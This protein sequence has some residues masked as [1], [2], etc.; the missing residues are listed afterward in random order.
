VPLKSSTKNSNKASGRNQ[1]QFLKSFC[2][3]KDTLNGRY[4]KFA[5][6]SSN[7]LFS[8]IQKNKIIQN[9]QLFLLYYLFIL[10]SEDFL[11]KKMALT[12][13]TLALLSTILAVPAS[14]LASV[15]AANTHF[16]DI[17]SVPWARDA[18]Q[19]LTASGVVHGVNSTQFDPNHSITREQFAKLVDLN[20]GLD[21]VSNMIPFKDVPTN[22]WSFDSIQRAT[23]YMDYYKSLSGSSFLFKPTVEMKRQD[24]AITLVKLLMAQKLITALPTDDQT[25]S[26]LAPYTDAK[27]VAATAQPYMAEAISIGLVKGYSDT[28]IGSLDPVTRAQAAVF[29]DRVDQNLLVVPTVPDPKPAPQPVDPGTTDGGTTTDPTP[30]SNDGGTTTT[31]PYDESTD[32]SGAGVGSNLH[33]LWSGYE[34]NIGS[35]VT[36]AGNAVVAADADSNGSI[37]AYELTTG[38]Q[39]WEYRQDM[40][41][42]GLLE[43]SPTTV[44]MTLGQNQSGVLAL[45]ASTGKPIWSNLSGNHIVAMKIKDGTAFLATSNTLYAFDASTGESLWSKPLKTGISTIEIGES[46]VAVGTTDGQLLGYTFDGNAAFAT[47]LFSLNVTGI[48][49]SHDTWV[50]T[51]GNVLTAV[52]KSGAIAW[53]LKTQNAIIGS[54]AVVDGDSVYAI[55]NDQK[56]SRIDLSKGTVLKV[57]SLAFPASSAPAVA[58]GLIYLTTS[59]GNLNTVDGISLKSVGTVTEGNR[60][61]GNLNMYATPLVYEGYVIGQSHHPGYSG[62]AQVITL[63]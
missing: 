16:Q 56:I 18:I 41:Y 26:I 1:T 27:E 9:R 15:S 17:K 61:S 13:S 63:N 58:N 20:F 12:V 50:V 55:T 34:G 49:T 35:N 30:T 37:Y 57:N 23:P 14:V 48:S 19:R 59:Q 31:P 52:N 51:Q 43:G 53:A 38:K 42:N 33:V 39:L 25:A 4:P 40:Y 5:N 29:L 44:L 3:P 36:I 47:K 8:L 7:S 46:E 11:V 28:E 22:K 60:Y 24:L 54:K 32:D 10:Q 6:R 45:S 2:S 21:D 62:D